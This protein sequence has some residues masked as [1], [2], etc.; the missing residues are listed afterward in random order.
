[1]A[2]SGKQPASS[3][4]G[5]ALAEAA[6]TLRLRGVRVHNLKNLDL[7]LPRNQFVVITGVSGSGK[8]SLAFDTIFAEG[9]RQFIESLSPYARQFLQQLERPD[10][11]LIEGLEPTIAIDQRGGSVQPRSTVG[12][13]TEIYDYLRILMARAGTPHCPEC[14]TEIRQ[15]SREQIIDRVAEFPSGTKAMILAPLVRGR[16]GKHAEI[17]EQIRKSGFVRARIDGQIYDMDSLPEISPRKN[18]D[19]DAIVDR[20]IIRDEPQARV[21][22]SIN[23]ALQQGDGVIGLNYLL[24]DERTWQDITFST[25]F[26]CPRCEDVNFAEIEP[27]TFSFNS[28]YGACPTCTGLGVVGDDA[29]LKELEKNA[30]DVDDSTMAVCP[31]CGGAR[32][33][34]E[35]LSVTLGEKNIDEICRLPLDEAIT[36]FAGLTF[37]AREQEIADRALPD[38]ISRLEMLDRLGVGYLSLSRTARTLSGGEAQRVRLASAIG[39]GLVGVCYVLDEP[40]IGLHPA[41]NDRLIDALRELQQQGNTL[42]VVEHGEAMMRAADYLLDLGPGAG[43]AGGEIVAEGTADE[44]AEQETSLTGQYLSGRKQVFQPREARRFDPNRALKLTGASAHNL[45][46]LTVR[47]PLT[48]FTCV[49][50]VSGSGKSTL[51]M[52]TLCPAVAKG[53]GSETA[54]PLPHKSLTG[55]DQLERFVEVD[56]TPIGRSPR[57]NPATYTGVLDEV[58]K[59]FAATKEAKLRGFKAERFSF[60]NKAGRC[61]ACGGAGQTKIE[62]KFLP[63]LYVTCSACGGK[64]FNQQTLEILYRGQSVA[65]VLAMSADEAC[66]FFQNFPKIHRVLETV[67]DVGLGYL[68]L[69]QSSLTLSGGEAQRVKLATELA[70]RTEGRGLYILDEPTTGLH[71]D[72]VRKLLEILHRLV[73]VGNTVIVIEHQTDVIR[74]ADWVVDLGPGGG[75]S[76]GTLVYEGPPDGLAK[77]KNSPTAQ[78]CFD[79]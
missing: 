10:V 41:D 47:F 79:A 4:A 6:E 27:R 21:A 72:D 78:A 56:Q 33:R 5:V 49:T 51:V 37:N 3:S 36:F 48:A 70:R 67:C 43:A 2:K 50:G 7:D 68:T 75:K 14:G 44:V 66:D 73:D 39:A 23:L 46:N 52:E 69:G 17:I 26:A 32:L 18:H 35:A 12:T 8:S 22:E 20:V 13:V 63:D 57:S 76:G 25:Q 59:V 34:P 53:L 15:Q 77:A 64:R 30:E 19:I 60:N 71:F 28:P 54:A 29:V 61:E 42:L 16:K 62:M 9:Q 55:V 45:R 11:D 31:D 40:S 65:D 58:R 38:I 74:S 1:M 24:P